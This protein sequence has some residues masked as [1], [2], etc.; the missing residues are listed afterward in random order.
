[1]QLLR[2]AALKD[3]NGANDAY[4]ECIKYLTTYAYHAR[5]YLAE[6]DITAGNIDQ[7][8]ETLK[9]NLDLLRSDNDPEA[10]QKTLLALGDLY[11]KHGNYSK[12]VERLKVALTA[13]RFPADPASTRAHYQ[14]ADSYRRLA[15]KTIMSAAGADAGQSPEKIGQKRK[16][17]L[18]YLVNAAAEFE[19]SGGSSLDK[20]EGKNLLTPEERVQVPFLAADCHFDQGE[21]P[22]RPGGLRTPAARYAERLERPGTPWAAWCAVIPPLG[23]TEKMEQTLIRIEQ[24]LPKMPDAVGRQWSEWLKTARKPVSPS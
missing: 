16:E 6:A 12:A 17:Y 4:R 9:Q 15:D 11:Y 14:L 18:D 7:A 8:V 20:P 3:A 10:H 21:Y 2:I 5:Y 13:G 19:G 1:M 23:D 24:M 22:G